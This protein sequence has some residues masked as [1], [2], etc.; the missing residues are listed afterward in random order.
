M[1]TLKNLENFQQ[2][3]PRSE[4]WSNLFTGEPVTFKA[5]WSAIAAV[6][7]D[8]NVPEAVRSYFATIQKLSVYGWFA[9]DFYAVGVFLSY[10][11][12][13]MALRLRFPIAGKDTRGLSTLLRE[14][15][16]K[17]LIKEK[18]FSHIRRIRQR[19]AEYIRLQR[20]YQ[21]IP[22]SSVPR[23]DYAEVLRKVLPNLRNSFAHP[24]GHS[25]CMPGDALFALRFAAEFINQLFDSPS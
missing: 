1:E 25:I 20:Q 24:R 14:A 6:T 2:A 23:S 10:T 16:K 5:R 7:L 22:R 9:Y 11:L 15:I 8:S 21:N 17:N 18:E 3:D 19:K 12:I 13:E 4:C